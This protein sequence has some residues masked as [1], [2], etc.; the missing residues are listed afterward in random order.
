MA[1][2]ADLRKCAGRNPLLVLFISIVPHRKR[3][4]TPFSR[5]TVIPDG[6]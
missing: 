1:M 3:H 5:L 6:K 4:L 2:R